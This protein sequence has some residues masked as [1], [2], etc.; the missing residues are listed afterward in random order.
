MTPFDLSLDFGYQPPAGW[1]KWHDSSV[2]SG[3]LKA[4]LPNLEAAYTNEFVKYW[5]GKR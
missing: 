5:N 3:I 2:A 4:P 1:K